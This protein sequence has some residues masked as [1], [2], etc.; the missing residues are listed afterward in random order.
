MEPFLA[1]MR[2]AF[3]PNYMVHLQRLID[4]MPDGLDL[5]LRLRK[6]IGAAT[7]SRDSRTGAYGSVKRSAPKTM[8]AWATDGV[9]AA[10][11]HGAR[12]T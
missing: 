1:E 5:W 12:V 10:T 6:D 4:A 9:P 8:L 7:V 2:A 11:D 3:A